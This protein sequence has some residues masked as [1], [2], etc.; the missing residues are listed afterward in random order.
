M[1][2]YCAIIKMTFQSYINGI[3]MYDDG[4]WGEK[5]KK[6]TRGQGDCQQ[7]NERED[8]TSRL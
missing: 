7:S 1:I 6:N 8:W 4:K 5:P 2:N 3:R